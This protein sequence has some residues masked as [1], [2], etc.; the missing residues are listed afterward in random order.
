MN[1]AIPMTK[2][3]DRIVKLDLGVEPEAAVSGALLLQNENATYLTF[4]AVRLR[5]DGKYEEAGTAVIELVRCSTTTF[6]YPNDEAIGGHPLYAKGLQAYG[7]FEVL[8]SSWI[9]EQER[10]NR[11]SFPERTDMTWKRHFIFTFHDSTFECLSADLKITVS[12]EPY[13]Q[14]FAEISEQVL[15]NQC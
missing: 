6:G 3:K 5:F 15:I 12:E 9:A 2:E 11:I 1:F 8:N 7:I 10:Q 14:I 4:N 13:A